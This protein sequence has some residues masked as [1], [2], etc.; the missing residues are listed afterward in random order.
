MEG[1]AYSLPSPSH[2]IRWRLRR[3]RNGIRR[4]NGRNGKSIEHGNNTPT[5]ADQKY[6]ASLAQRL[7][8]RCCRRTFRRVRRCNAMAGI[9]TA[10]RL[11]PRETAV[12]R[13]LAADKAAQGP[14]ASHRHRHRRPAG[15]HPGFHVA[16]IQD[17]DGALW[18][19]HFHPPPPRL[20][21]PLL[22]PVF[23]D[24]P[25]AAPLE[26]ACDGDFSQSEFSRL[27]R[28]SVRGNFRKHLPTTEPLPRFPL[29]R[30][31]RRYPQS[32]WRLRP[33]YS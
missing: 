30:H 4:R 21:V 29:D 20:S 23:A 1:F 32:C 16:N 19:A 31:R 13:A 10:G 17:H 12:H 18:R 3:W 5:S 2:A 6:G 8:W 28:G 26:A 11:R 15:G 27:L 14:P 33:A 25:Y 9:E 7:P 22:R 24:G